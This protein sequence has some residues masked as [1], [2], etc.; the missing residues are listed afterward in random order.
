LIVSVIQPSSLVSKAANFG[1]LHLQAAE[2]VM[3][4]AGVKTVGYYATSAA[5]FASSRQTVG[6]RCGGGGSIPDSCTAALP[7]IAILRALAET[8]RESGMIMNLVF[9]AAWIH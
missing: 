5:A 7:P 2:P 9:A 6:W 4:A 3:S 1:F 8:A